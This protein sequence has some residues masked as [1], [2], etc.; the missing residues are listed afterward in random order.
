MSK[1][2]DL[3][4]NYNSSGT[5]FNMHKLSKTKNVKKVLVKKIKAIYIA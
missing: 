4:S 2:N 1:H 3:S 5:S